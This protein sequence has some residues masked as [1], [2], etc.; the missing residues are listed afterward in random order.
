MFGP[1][2]GVDNKIARRR[3]LVFI[4][5]SGVFLGTLAV[6]NILGLSRQID[7]SFSIGNLNI[8]FIVFVGVLPYPITFLCTDFISELYGRRRANTVVWVGLLLNLWV[9][10]ILWIGGALPPHPELGANGLPD[11]SH[12]NYS[13]FHIRSLTKMATIASMIAYLTAQFVDVQIFHLLKKLTKGKA[14]W[15]RNNGSTL[16]SQMVDSVAVILITYSFS[17]AIHIHP[18]ETVSHGLF[19]LIMSNYTFKMV[20]AFID[21]IPFYIG[22]KFLSRYLQIDPNKEF[23]DK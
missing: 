5:L 3:E 9:L 13:F 16:T 8:P 6:L 19:I 1:T 21:T 14:L 22:V 4:I 2:D 15:L 20:S 7:L 18:G 17:D 11:V 10:F 23:R 12:P